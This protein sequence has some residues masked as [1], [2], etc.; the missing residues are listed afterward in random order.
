MAFHDHTENVV[1]AAPVLNQLRK[2]DHGGMLIAVQ[3]DHAVDK[4]LTVVAHFLSPFL[5]FSEVII[6]QDWLFVKHFLADQRKL[7]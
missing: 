3:V 4:G 5:L 6:A 7:F 2:L 1:T